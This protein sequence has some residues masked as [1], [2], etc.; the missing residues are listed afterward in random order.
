MHLCKYSYS[1][2]NTKIYPNKIALFIITRIMR[3]RLVVSMHKWLT[4]KQFRVLLT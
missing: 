4:T 1:Q 3:F 2:N